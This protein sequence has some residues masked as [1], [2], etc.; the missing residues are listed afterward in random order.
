MIPLEKLSLTGTSVSAADILAMIK[1]LPNLKTL[2]LGAL[3]GGQGSATSMVSPSAL[4]MNEDML[5]TLTNILG[6]FSNLEYV[7]LVG[8]AELGFNRKGEGAIASFIRRVG[9][10]CKV[11]S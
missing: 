2:S 8:N 11:C 3:G 5:F 10:N 6:E 9:R 1:L 7:N 4:T